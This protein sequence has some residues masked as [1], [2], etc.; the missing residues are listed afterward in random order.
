VLVHDKLQSLYQGRP[1]CLH[2]SGTNLPLLF[3]DEYEELEL[4]NALTYSDQSNASIS[5]SYSISNFTQT[6]SLSV[7]LERIFMSLYTER[8]E[9]RDPEDLLRECNSLHEQIKTWRNS[10]PP[11]LEILSSDTD[12]C[13]PMPHTLALL[14]G[15]PF[16]FIC[17]LL[18]ALE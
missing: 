8:S 4:F 2:N 12:T 7:I 17:H 15:P 5:V 10:L 13:V 6:C 18:R 9:S 1:S 14:Y 3:L 16:I 11:Q